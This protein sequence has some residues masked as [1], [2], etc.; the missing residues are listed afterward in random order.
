ME[1][2]RGRE[3]EVRGLQVQEAGNKKRRPIGRW[4]NGHDGHGIYGGN[5]GP[6]QGVCSGAVLGLKEKG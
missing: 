2:E 5:R 6:G 1:E 4:G 3:N